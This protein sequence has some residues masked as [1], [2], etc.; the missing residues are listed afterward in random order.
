[1]MRDSFVSGFVSK[2]EEGGAEP[3]ANERWLSDSP[4]LR[5]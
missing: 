2:D 4:V 3:L 1:M 5:Q